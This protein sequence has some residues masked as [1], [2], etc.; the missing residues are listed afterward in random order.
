M[1]TIDVLSAAAI[2]AGA[3]TVGAGA[4]ALM[5]DSSSVTADL[6][7]SNAV[8]TN[9]SSSS[10]CSARTVTSEPAVVLTVI[11]IGAS[12]LATDISFFKWSNE[13]LFVSPLSY[14]HCELYS[15]PALFNVYPN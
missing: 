11:L 4:V 3:I 14:F 12:V 9:W 2:C 6:I 7:A 1:S 10:P 13:T 8:A 15:L 5:A